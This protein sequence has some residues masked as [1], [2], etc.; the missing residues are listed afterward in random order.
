VIIQ[1][2]SAPL[3]L[4]LDVVSFLTSA[5]L[6]GKVSV[7]EP[8]GTGAA[9]KRQLREAF[10]FI[11]RNSTLLAKFASGVVLNFFYTI[12]FTLLFLFAVKE[13]GLS[14]GLVGL[15]VSVG[16]I[17]ALLGAAVA[18][19]MSGRLGIGATFI[20]GALLFPAALVLTPLAQGDTWLVTTMLVIGEFASAFG[21][22]LFDI[23]GST[24]QQ[25]ITPDRLRS[26]MQGAHMAISYGVRPIGSLAAG[27][28]GTWLGLR[29]TLWLAVVGGFVGVLF[30]FA[31]PVR[32][33]RELPAESD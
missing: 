28:L 30:L 21:L 33:M 22:M 31:T 13:L 8:A 15:V 5:W 27:G 19:R 7:T 23:T 29:P 10:E 3:V 14:A 25:A 12:Y 24:I 17:G 16:A 11:R 26:R 32:S 20:A 1:V 18:T 4:L 2:L 9:A 6:L